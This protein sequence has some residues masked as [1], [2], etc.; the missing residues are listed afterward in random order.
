[1]KI[2]SVLYNRYFFLASGHVFPVGFTSSSK[3]E[4]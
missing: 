4:K 1:M 2:E 3:T